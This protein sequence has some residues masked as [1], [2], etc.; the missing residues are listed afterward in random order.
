MDLNV[1]IHR[2]YV[3]MKERPYC[4]NGFEIDLGEIRMNNQY[5][6]AKGRF[7]NALEKEVHMTY[8]V[9]DAKDLGIINSKDRFRVS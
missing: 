4:E 8:F 7:K 5:K 6:T 3:I 1:F 2:P 9:V